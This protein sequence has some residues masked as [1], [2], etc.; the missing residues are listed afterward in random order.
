MRM[1]IFQKNNKKAVKE[2]K[3][4]SG[5]YFRENNIT[6]KCYVGS[7]VFLGKRLINYF[8]F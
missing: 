7:S 2:N 6:G 5:V 1:Q 8:S 4:R 3:G